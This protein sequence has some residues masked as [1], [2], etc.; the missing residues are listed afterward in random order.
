MT[1]WQI[2]GGTVLTN[3]GLWNDVDVVTE[4]ATIARLGG[5]AGAPATGEIDARGLL[6]LPGIVDLHGDA[7]ERQIMPRPGVGFPLG[8]ALAD[9]DRQI[10]ANG[11]TTAFHGISIS[12]EPGLRSEAHSLEL[13]AELRAHAPHLKADT[14]IHL[15]W[16]TFALDAIPAVERVLAE[17][18][19][20]ILAFNDHT[21]GTMRK[22]WS[23]AKLQQWSERSGLSTEDYT[24]LLERVWARRDEVPEAIRRLAQNG[25]AHGAVLLAH[26][27][28]SPED[29][30]HF[31]ALGAQVCE[32]P[33][34]RPTAQLA[35]EAGEHVV[36]G[37]PNILRGGSHVGALNARDAIAEGLCSVLASDYYYPAPLAAALKLARDHGMAI[38]SVWPIVSR[39]PAEAAGLAD[40]GV[41]A[42][43]R[44]ADLVLVDVRGEVP[45]LVATIAGGRLAYAAD[46]RLFQRRAA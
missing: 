8:L 6:V 25:L 32:F 22:Q 28:A 7:F 24:A 33:L 46:D 1:R 27:E 29:R 36:L 13:I 34:N 44:R 43:G 17:A 14:R 4:D 9:T 2:S 18:P 42:A 39:H 12:W 3:D 38:E 40:R 15:R 30:R 19:G 31:R 10:V 35:R 21:T 41:I 26:D 16:E 11:I 20:S 37:A 45:R 23:R 5:G